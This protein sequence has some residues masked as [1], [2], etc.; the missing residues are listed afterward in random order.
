MV[1]PP[2]LGK[3]QGL[4]DTSISRA[5]SQTP[6]ERPMR[7]IGEPQRQIGDPG[8]GVSGAPA[9]LPIRIGPIE[10]GNR[11]SQ[12]TS[13]IGLTNRPVQDWAGAVPDHRTV[14]SA[15]AAAR[16]PMLCI[17]R[18]VPAQRRHHELSASR[19]TAAARCRPDR[20]LTVPC[21][22]AT[23]ISATVRSLP[24]LSR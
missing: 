22:P 17:T 15:T 10:I 6:S 19:A 18:H 13:E 1:S 24:S 4:R 2:R 12:H 9:A 21:H 3:H 20:M 23:T 14:S 7:G 11:H 16:G 8:F 5:G